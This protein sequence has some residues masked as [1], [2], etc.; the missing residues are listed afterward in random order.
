V[1]DTETQLREAMRT[2]TSASPGVV[3]FD[4]IGHRV[5]RRRKHTAIAASV[6]VAV[7]AIAPVTVLQFGLVGDR[8][9]PIHGPTT[10]T[11]PTSA[12]KPIDTS[13]VD[14]SIVQK[15]WTD[16]RWATLPWSST[17]VPRQLDPLA[18]GTTSL[19]ADPVRRALAAVQD[20][21]GGPI[22]VLGE[23]GRWRK[24]DLID[25]EPREDSEGSPSGGALGVG[26]LSADG[27]KL[28]VPQPHGLIVID[29]EANTAR[30][31][32][33]PGQPQRVKWDPAGSDVL[34]Y[35]YAD[36]YPF[37]EVSLLVDAET[38]SSRQVPYNAELTSFADDG[39]AVEVHRYTAFR[40][41]G[42]DELRRY[43]T[44]G[45]MTAVPTQVD[46]FEDS[47]SVIA[48]GADAVAVMRDVWMSKVPR[49]AG[50]WPGPTILD[51]DT[52]Q[53]LAQLP[54][55]E[56]ANALYWIAPVG[57]VDKDTVLLR[58]GDHLVAWDYRSG[59]LSRVSTVAKV[60][61]VPPI[62]MDTKPVVTIATALI[63]ID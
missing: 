30:R 12:A 42:Y 27:S 26:S 22:Y 36:G 18:A 53:P 19:K 43:D 11:T 3:D 23:D 58:L 59:S 56:L 6:A 8:E 63:G 9:Q 35:S 52:G 49:P 38:G 16:K 40:P 20:M 47:P 55:P 7:A 10:P 21:D 62:G 31:H 37:R 60:S 48:A 29:L 1:K 5:R 54:V 24:Q 25:V 45:A 28:S 39:T 14:P 2:A 51:L 61:R 44:E 57:W 13:E 33:L 41:N 15:P 46:L 32:P 34:V 50:S 17:K 4:Q